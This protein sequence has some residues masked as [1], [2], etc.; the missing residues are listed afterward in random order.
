MRYLRVAVLAPAVFCLSLLSACSGDADSDSGDAS[1]DTPGA[2]ADCQWKP[3]GEPSKKV[4][5]PA[6]DAQPAKNLV[7]KTS[8]GDVPIELDPDVVCASTSFTWLSEEGFYD[9][10][11]C[12]RLIVASDQNP[13]GIVQCGDP[14]GSGTGGPGYS[15]ADELSGD[16]QYKAGTIAMANSGPNTN[17]SQFFLNYSD[18]QFPPN[19]TLFG[20]IKPEGIKVLKKV[21][22]GGTDTGQ[23]EGAPKKP[24]TIESVEVVE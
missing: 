15:F 16:E 2:A 7:L 19:Y 23:S 1:A 11:E 8:G 22:D 17:G 20:T 13:T 12:H 14:S 5:P 4:D 6:S 18:S 10:T 21:A 9:D 24:F 3:S